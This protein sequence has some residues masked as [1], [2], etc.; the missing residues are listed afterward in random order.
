LVPKGPKGGTN[1]KGRRIIPHANLKT[2]KDHRIEEI[3]EAI[4][5][6]DYL[7]TQKNIPRITSWSSGNRSP[8]FFLFAAP[9]R[10]AQTALATARNL[11]IDKP[12]SHSSVPETDPHLA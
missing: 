8:G 9:C 6:L 12:S 7:P 11:Y 1:W 2:L 5:L 4:L 3:E 10:G